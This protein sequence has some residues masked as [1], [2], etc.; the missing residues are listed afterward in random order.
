MKLTVITDAGGE[1]IA[2]AFEEDLR[3]TG[4]DPQS[5]LLAPKPEHSIHEIEVPSNFKQLPWDELKARVQT[6]PAISAKRACRVEEANNP[7]APMDTTEPRR[8]RYA[9]SQEDLDEQIFAPI[10]VKRPIVVVP[11]IMGSDLWT[12]TSTGD[13]GAQLW[14]PYT[15]AGGAPE[16]AKISKLDAAVPK[17]AL[18]GAIF[19]GVYGELL[20]ALRK[21]GYQDSPIPPNP[22]TLWI[23]PY[24]WTISCEDA[25]KQLAEF[26]V[27]TVLSSKYPAW[28]S[29]DIVNHS[30]GGIVTRA[31]KEIYG[32]PISRSAYIASPH[33]GSAIAFLALHPAINV[34]FFDKSL[35]LILS[36]VLNISNPLALLRE[37]VLK[38][39]SAYDLLP[40][41]AYGPI[42]SAAYRRFPLEMQAEIR[43]ARTFKARLGSGPRERHII[44]SC[45][46][47]ATE[48]RSGW[49]SMR[50][51][52]PAL[53]FL[54]PK[55]DQAEDALDA[56]SY[57]G[58]NSGR[59][60]TVDGTH[61][62]VPSMKTVH[63][64][65]HEFLSSN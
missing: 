46:T 64:Y 52:L 55:P 17:L 57:V 56:T 58:T 38:W 36:M 11:G 12:K 65:L 15:A 22:K 19:H 45:S 27:S 31:A 16:L 50:L 35:D 39:K 48:R 40:D 2:T 62:W 23:F 30:M 47:K 6:H 60:I 25:G 7:Q 14:P 33:N 53:R 1:I 13:Q 59:S 43:R 34:R 26:I 24:D 42:Q 5:G 49:R 4:D 20:A 63:A 18:A 21:M 44:F 54:N 10:E 32:A 8:R 9:A 41:D 3:V 37:Q 51:S 29:V 28:E 61:L